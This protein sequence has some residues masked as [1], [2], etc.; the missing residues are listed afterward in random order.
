LNGFKHRR[1]A[2]LNQVSWSI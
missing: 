2:S 1:L